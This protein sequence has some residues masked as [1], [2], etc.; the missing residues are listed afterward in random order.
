MTMKNPEPGKNDRFDFERLTIY[1]KAIALTKR[2]APITLEPPRKAAKLCDHLDRAVDSVLLNVPEGSGRTPR[3]KDRRHFYRIALGSAK[4]AASAVIA[5]HAKGLISSTLYQDAR[6]LL[7]EIVRML[8]V[9]ARE[10]G[11][12]SPR[13]T[14]PPA[15]GTV[16]EKGKRKS[17]GKGKGKRKRKRRRMWPVS[18]RAGEEYTDRRIRLVRRWSLSWSSLG[19]GIWRLGF[20]GERP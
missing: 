9:M 10:W 20:R 4:E 19:I 17:K 14:R 13:S 11:T 5:L 7:L 18:P 1:S 2:L 6:A 16:S 12:P 8:S 3:S 15:P